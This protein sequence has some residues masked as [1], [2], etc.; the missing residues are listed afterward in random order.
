MRGTVLAEQLWRDLRHVIRGLRARPVFTIGVAGTLALGI[1]ANAAMFGI[2]DRLMFRD[3]AGLREPARVRRVYLQWTE[4]GER[5]TDRNMAFPRYRDFVR[6]ARTVDAV[7]AFQVR[8]VALGRGEESR[9]ARAAVVSASYLGFFDAPPAL[10]RWFT[11]LEDDAPAGAEVVVLGYDYW[12]TRYGGRRDV[13]GQTLQ[14][15]RMTATIVGVAPPEF[16]GVADEGAA[17]GVR[18]DECLRPLDARYRICG[19]VQLGVA[20]T[21]RAASSGGD[22]RGGVGRH[23]PSARLELAT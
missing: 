19:V 18:A 10:G 8:T 13:L 1:G 4:D 17:F 2:V 15:D 11:A 22:G 20:R 9:E 21:A 16:S 23:E 14:V 3:P 12:Q 6:D 5:R 7:G